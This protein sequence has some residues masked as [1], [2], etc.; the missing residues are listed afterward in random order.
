M[1]AI[2]LLEQQ[3]EE[4]MQMLNTLKES[5]P[6]RQRNETFKKLQHSLLAHMVIEEEL[7]YPALV[8]HSSEGEPVA[9]GYEEHAGARVALMRC[10][11]ALKQEEL[12]QVRI[13]VLKE[14][15]KHHVEEERETMLPKA[16]ETMPAEARESLGTQ[17]E[18][19]FQK[20]TRMDPAADL[21]RKA[22]SRE[23]RALSA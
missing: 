19:R 22:T 9:E 23:L 13:G 3:H 16:R 20:A 5:T 17:M 1:D 12:F 14:M 8:S 7:F 21:N 4:T 11:R 15:I 10:Q 18:A 6:G 2:D